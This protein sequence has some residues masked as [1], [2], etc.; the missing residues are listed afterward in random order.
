MSFYAVIGD[1]VSHSKSPLIHSLFATQTGESISYIAQKVVA[2]KFE[3]FV[4]EF[5]EGGGLGLNVTL[6][7]KERA[8]KLARNCDK[9]AQT[10][11]AANTLFLDST[12]EICAA[13]TDGP[14]LVA[15]IKLNN[16]VQI[17]GKDLLLLGAG[18]AVRGAL[19]SLIEEKPS[20]ITVVNRTLSRANSLKNKFN[21]IPR[22]KT[23]TYDDLDH[24]YDLIINGTS[25]GLTNE[26][27]PL[28]AMNVRQGAFCYDM[29]YADGQTAF[30]HWAKANGAEKAIDGLGMLVE[31]AAESFLLWRGVRPETRPVIEELKKA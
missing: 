24:D 18:G 1:P 29:F 12:G 19:V 13:N 5:F 20:S 30:V 3:A 15:D 27:P 9:G 7:H 14:G 26:V 4:S 16:G 10:A 17:R 8:Y 31:Q 2:D 22:I 23:S 11:E 28:K 6:P 21:K 25:L